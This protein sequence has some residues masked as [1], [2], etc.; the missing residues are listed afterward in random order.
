[1]RTAKTD[2]TGRM[3]GAHSFCWFC[4]VAAQMFRQY[5]TTY[6]NGIYEDQLLKCEWFCKHL[7]TVEHVNHLCIKCVGNTGKRHS[8]E[9]F[10]DKLQ[11]LWNNHS[12]VGRKYSLAPPKTIILQ[13]QWSKHLSNLF[14][15]FK[16]KWPP[17]KWFRYSCYD[18]G[19]HP[20]RSGL[21]IPS[22]G[23]LFRPLAYLNWNF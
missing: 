15:L 20:W 16:P 10:E 21:T 5:L 11:F 3:L 9:V 1:M 8:S 7:T 6:L 19:C 22:R 18:V 13:N 23:Y 2:Q 17:G 14:T 12:S 4:H